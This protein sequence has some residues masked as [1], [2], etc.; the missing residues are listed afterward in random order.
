[1]VEEKPQV[2]PQ[3]SGEYRAIDS[4]YRRDV[5]IV[6]ARPKLET[7]AFVVWALID[8]LLLLVFVFGVIMYIVSGSFEDARTSASILQ[9]VQA[10]HAGVTRAAPLELAVDSA[11][12]ASVTSG[13]YDLYSTVENTNDDW[14]TTFD[15]IFEYDNGATEVY[16]GFVNPNEKRVLAAINVAAERRPSGLNIVLQNQVW[17]RV[18]KHAILDTERFLDERS[19]ITV[20]S[21]SYSKDVTLGEDQLGRSTIV[22][23]NRTAYAYWDPEFLVKL[24]RGSTV[25]SI[26]KVSVPEFMSNETRTLE[27]R[28]FGEVP[29]S[30]TIGVEP[31][32]LYFDDGVY[33]NPDDERGRD[34][35]R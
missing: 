6:N 16:Q 32:I 19:N 24:M 30:G 27:V 34:V 26:T 8:V 17:H 3:I 23:T 4:R 22:L 1:M 31:M 33:M 29:P 13:K 11:K 21:A 14:Y 18:D 35:R 28:W 5:A 2:Q 7:G 15:Y 10:S 20:D 9:N 25:V 12:S